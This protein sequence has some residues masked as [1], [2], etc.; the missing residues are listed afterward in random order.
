MFHAGRMPASVLKQCVLKLSLHSY[1]FTYLLQQIPVCC[2]HRV[3]QS[4]LDGSHRQVVVEGFRYPKSL[5]VFAHH[6]YFA[7]SDGS[8]LLALS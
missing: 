4:S 1:V 8:M 2:R 3:E 7:N 5:A 6:I